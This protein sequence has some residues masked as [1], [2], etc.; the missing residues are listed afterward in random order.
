MRSST[1]FLEGVWQTDIAGYGHR[2]QFLYSNPAHN[3]GRK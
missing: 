3:E 2:F 1:T